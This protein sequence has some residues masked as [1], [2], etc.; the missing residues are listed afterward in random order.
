V[1]NFTTAHQITAEDIVFTFNALTKDGHPRDTGSISAMS[2]PGRGNISRAASNSRSSRVP[3]ATCR[4]G[5]HA[6]PVL[7]KT[8][9]DKVEFKKTTF[10]SRRWPA[11]PTAS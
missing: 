1:Q 4:R 3:T 7:S 11:A 5:W 6:L 2:R 8:Y 9:Y 10:E